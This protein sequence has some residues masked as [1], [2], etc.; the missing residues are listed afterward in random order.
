[1]V[2]HATEGSGRSGHEAGARGSRAGGSG[3]DDFDIVAA[4][5]WPGVPPNRALLGPAQCRTLWRQFSSD[6]AYAVQQVG[7]GS[8]LCS[9]A[10]HFWQLQ[11]FKKLLS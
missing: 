2:E 11:L 8:T 3:E 1:M 9:L 10:S 6:S 5:D 4:N 7:Q